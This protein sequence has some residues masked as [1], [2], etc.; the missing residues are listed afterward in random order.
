MSLIS[1]T[2]DHRMLFD[3]DDE[4]WDEYLDAVAPIVEMFSIWEHVDFFWSAY[5]DE[6]MSE[7]DTKMLC[8]TLVIYV[9]RTYI[10]EKSIPFFMRQ[11]VR[12]YV[13]IFTLVKNWCIGSMY[14]IICIAEMKCRQYLVE[15]HQAPVGWCCSICL[16][17]TMSHTVMKTHCNHY[18]H[19]GCASKLSS[20]T[21][22]ECRQHMYE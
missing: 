6:S 16:Q 22:P 5:H 15:P 9:V 7:E 3:T 4:S 20:P 11:L 12:A 17:K 13:P 18:F 8:L 14:K 21:C 1:Y 19:Y 2:A 10:H